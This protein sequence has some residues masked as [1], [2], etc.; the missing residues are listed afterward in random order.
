MLL[1]RRD[2][3]VVAVGALLGLAR[4]GAPATA[5]EPPDVLGTA[6][7]LGNGRYKGWKYGSNAE[8]QQIDCV[9][10]VLAVVKEFVPDLPAS[11]KT[12]ILI[13]D[14][15]GKDVEGDKEGIITKA[16]ARAKGV[17][18]ALVDLDQGEAVS[19]KDARPGDFIQYWMMRDNGTWFG[20][21]G[22]IE[23]VEVVQGTPRATIYG[24]H[25]SLD[26]IGSSK[27]TSRLRLVE[28]ADR[29]IY[30]VRLKG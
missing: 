23:K 20:H 15:K 17:Q 29:R 5:N 30:I 14:L 8:K 6:R 7:K 9:Q 24:S 1:N 13:S 18:Q 27:P 2:T 26:G 3:L 4:R 10:F 16:D 11:A 22:V 21:S 28:A 12:R 25:L 19:L